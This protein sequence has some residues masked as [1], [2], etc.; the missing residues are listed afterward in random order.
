MSVT[1]EDAT[2]TGM[3]AG[4][5][6]CASLRTKGMYLPL[7]PQADSNTPGGSA[8]AVFW[9]LRTMKMTGPDDDFV[10]PDACLPG[11]VC[12]KHEL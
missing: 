4:P 11:R 12:Y 5:R 2:H 10:A 8:T 1:P 3:Q 9:C 6:T 7:N